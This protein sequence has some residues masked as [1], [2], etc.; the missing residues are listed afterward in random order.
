VVDVTLARMA[1]YKVH[2]RAFSP[3][4]DLT[5]LAEPVRT[6]DKPPK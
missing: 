6:E 4:T 2:D 1:D 5:G 3:V